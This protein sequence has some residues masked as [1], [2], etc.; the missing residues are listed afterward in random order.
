MAEAVNPDYV[1]IDELEKRGQV[2]YYPGPP[3]NTITPCYC[4]KCETHFTCTHDYKTHSC[5]PKDKSKGKLSPT[6]LDKLPWTTFRKGNGE[7]IFS[8]KAIYLLE[9]ITNGN[10]TFGTYHYWLY[11]D[12]QFIARRKIS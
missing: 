11:G 3:G 4:G 9:A 7:W 6:D 5:T 12:N 1:T 10:T 2:I 8:N